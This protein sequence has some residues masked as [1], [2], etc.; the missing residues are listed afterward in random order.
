VTALVKA[1]F[2][3]ANLSSKTSF[4][5]ALDRVDRSQVQPILRR[6]VVEH[7][8]GMAMLDR[9]IDGLLAALQRRAIDDQGALRLVR[10]PGRQ[11]EG[12]G[13]NCLSTKGLV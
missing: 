6:E 13:P 1:A 5:P 3:P 12:N 2:W 9:A 11:V 7:H 4:F 10:Q 8:E